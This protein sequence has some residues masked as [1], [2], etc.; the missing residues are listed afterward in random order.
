MHVV[1]VVQ[2]TPLDTNY[3]S[4][5][6]KTIKQR[7]V[8]WVMDNGCEVI[9]KNTPKLKIPLSTSKA[10]CPFNSEVVNFSKR[11]VELVDS[12]EDF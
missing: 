2:T 9:N 10:I 12:F 1:I 3:P 4:I 7:D 8:N 11:G 6:G 5:G